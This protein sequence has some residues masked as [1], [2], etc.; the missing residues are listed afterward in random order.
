MTTTGAGGRATNNPE[1]SS[2]WDAVAA[3]IIP[4]HDGTATPTALSWTEWRGDAE[5]LNAIAILHRASQ[6][7]YRVHM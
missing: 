4:D 7:S 2:A 6:R 3:D 1:S 5:I